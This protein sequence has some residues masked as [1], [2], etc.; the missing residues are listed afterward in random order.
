MR[1][2]VAG[3]GK[4]IATRPFQLVT[5]R[6]WRGTAFGGARLLLG[7]LLA[8]PGGGQFRAAGEITRVRRIDRGRR[9]GDL[10][11]AALDAQ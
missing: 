7:G 5:G 4:E 11:V 6:S 2:R 9:V 3:A 10:E 1:S 8:V